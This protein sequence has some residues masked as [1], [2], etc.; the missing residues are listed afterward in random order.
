MFFSN[1]QIFSYTIHLA[2]LLFP[3]S[4]AA[5]NRLLEATKTYVCNTEFR[6][7]VFAYVNDILSLRRVKMQFGATF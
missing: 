7:C 4:F 6:A 5:S 3:F 1:M 2:Y